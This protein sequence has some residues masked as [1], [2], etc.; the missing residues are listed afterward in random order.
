MFTDIKIIVPND[1]GNA[2][3]K[4]ILRDFNVSLIMKDYTTLLENIADD[5][6]WNIIG[7]EVIEGKNE[8]IKKIDEISLALHK[9]HF[10]NSTGSDELVIM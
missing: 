8:F 7:D 4:T 10:R 1:C 6:T 9:L 3:K 5:I 2:P